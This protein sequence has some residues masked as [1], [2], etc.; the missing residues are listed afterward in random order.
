M[1][2][3]LLGWIVTLIAKLIGLAMMTL[4]VGVVSLAGYFYYKSDQP[5]QVAAAQRLAPG[6]TLREY[7][8]FTHTVWEK[9]D[10][11]SVLAGNNG[12]CI[13]IYGVMNP[14]AAFIFSP[15]QVNHYRAIRG[16]TAS[17]QYAEFLNGTV[18]PDE[19]AY[20]PWWKLPEIY[21]WQYENTVWFTT[22]LAGGNCRTRPLS[23][24]AHSQT[25]NP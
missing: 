21:W 19:I 10:A 20:G 24:T 25:G 12:G 8:Q 2:G 11:K 16:T 1:I 23:P 4:V 18:P 14:I 22:Y 9:A 17:T 15:L 7:M 5:M 6:I 13:P 3:K